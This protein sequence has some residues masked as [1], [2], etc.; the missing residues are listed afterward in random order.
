MTSVTGLSKGILQPFG[1]PLNPL[2]DSMADRAFPTPGSNHRP[3]PRIPRPAPT[4]RLFSGWLA[5]PVCLVLG[6]V[7]TPLAAGEGSVGSWSDWMAVGAFF[8]FSCGCLYWLFDAA[9][10]K[11]IR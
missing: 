1:T 2:P 8:G 6:A 5:V 10:R 3:M 9:R 4:R 11:A 7:V